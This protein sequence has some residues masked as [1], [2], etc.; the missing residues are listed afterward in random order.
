MK[1]FLYLKDLVKEVIQSNRLVPVIL[2]ETSV[3]Q[4]GKI[5]GLAAG[6]S[7][8][9]SGSEVVSFPR[10]LERENTF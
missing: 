4:V 3:P 6:L 7:R 2:P 9:R 8:Q 5:H 1:R 10:R